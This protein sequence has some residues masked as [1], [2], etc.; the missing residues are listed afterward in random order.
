MK[1]FA[2]SR[3]TKEDENNEKIEKELRHHIKTSQL[4]NN[5]QELNTLVE[6]KSDT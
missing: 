1:Y 3:Y 5:Y 2:Y 6:K 4:N